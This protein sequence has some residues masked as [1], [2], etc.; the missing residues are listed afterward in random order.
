LRRSLPAA[1]AIV[2]FAGIAAPARADDDVTAGRPPA[3]TVVLPT[4]TGTS[5]NGTDGYGKGDEADGYGK[6][7]ETNGTGPSL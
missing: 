5:V 2:A 4:G 6:G 7:D 1:A 3:A